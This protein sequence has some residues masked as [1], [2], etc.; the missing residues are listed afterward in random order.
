MMSKSSTLL[1]K[2]REFRASIGTVDERADTLVLRGAFASADEQ[3]EW[4]HLRRTPPAPFTSVEIHN[5]DISGDLEDEDEFSHSQSYVITVGKPK[6]EGVAY[7]LFEEGA[8]KS[9]QAADQ[10]RQILVAAFD[11]LSAFRTRGFDVNR[12]D[13]DAEL[14]SPPSREIVSPVKLVSDYVP[15]REIVPDLA[16]WIW[17][18]LPVQSSTLYEK[19][20]VVAARRLLGGLVSSAW[21][22]NGQ[23]WLQASGPPVF[24]LRADDTSIAAAWEILTDAAVWVY[25]SGPDIEARH[26]LFTGE[27][28]RAD[29]PGQTVVETLKRA[30]EAADVA[31][32]AHI[33]SSSRETLKA[34]GDLRKTVIDETQK[35]TQ[36]AQDLTTMLWRDVAVSSAPFVLKLFGDVGK[37]DSSL[38]AAGFYFMAALF[39]TLSFGFQWRINGAFLKSQETSRKRWLQ[40]LYTYISV[41]ERAEIAEEP[42]EQA[43]KNYRETRNLLLPIYIAM[44]IIL[45]A[46][47]WHTLHRKQ[48]LPAE[49]SFQSIVPSPGTAGGPKPIDAPS[50]SPK[51]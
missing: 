26:R 46:F 1:A 51:L 35:V 4:L 20:Q 47:G 41:R 24:R 31:Y 13:L 15:N 25:L 32:A 39:I 22:E 10:P 18:T 7:F 3:A 34:L 19:W 21:L 12:W 8:I 29:R 16:P 23:V 48:I 5:P 45:V 9:L 14:V 33:Q 37:I 50:L 40:T 6:T 11:D 38:I 49:T 43:M 44:V 42:I 2:A 36:R 30:R 28:A 27:L 17:T